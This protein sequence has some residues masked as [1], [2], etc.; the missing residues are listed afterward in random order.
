MPFTYDIDEQPSSEIDPQALQHH[1]YVQLAPNRKRLVPGMLH[2]G[3]KPAGSNWLDVTEIDRE[4]EARYF[5]AYTDHNTLVPGSLIQATKLPKGQWKEIKIASTKFHKATFSDPYP[6]LYFG[7]GVPG[8]TDPVDTQNDFITDRVNTVLLI[9]YPDIPEKTQPGLFFKLVNGKDINFNL[10][11]FKGTFNELDRDVTKLV[12]FSNTNNLFITNQV[13]VPQPSTNI[14]AYM[15]TNNSLKIKSDAPD[16]S[17][18]FVLELLNVGDHK[19]YLVLE[20]VLLK[21][22]MSIDL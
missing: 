6:L 15:I 22:T 21:S 3:D 13:N 5:V 12:P 20:N 9:L 11:Y 7:S 10:Y 8:N 1:Y 16:G 14:S 2:Q 17:Y 4:L 18:S 19:E